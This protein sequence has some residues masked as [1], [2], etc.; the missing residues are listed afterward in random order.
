[1]NTN[2]AAPSSKSRAGSSQSSET[3]FKRKRGVF[4][5]ECEYSKNGF[6]LLGLLHS[7]ILL[8]YYYYSFL[9]FTVQHMMYGFGDDPNVSCAV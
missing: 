9:G 5:K 1:M 6:A 2:S 8:P 7:F 4:Q 3:S